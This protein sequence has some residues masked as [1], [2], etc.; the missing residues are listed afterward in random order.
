MKDYPVPLALKVL[1]KNPSISDR[2]N[3][4]NVACRG[5]QGVIDLEIDPSCEELITDLEQVITDGKQ[6][7]KKTFN[8]KDP[9]YRRT[10]M[11][12]ALGYWVSFEAPI[13]PIVIE[14]V[15]RH[16]PVPKSPGYR[17]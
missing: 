7:I 5:L 16:V 2:V 17:R 11:S 8:K 9:Y 13:V 6:G 10:H 14:Q 1:D 4:V 15:K 12:D 3:S